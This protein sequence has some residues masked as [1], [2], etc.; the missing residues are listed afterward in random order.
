MI[1]VQFIID[2]KCINSK[3]LPFVYQIFKEITCSSIVVNLEENF[4]N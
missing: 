1:S 2:T 4:I 3:N